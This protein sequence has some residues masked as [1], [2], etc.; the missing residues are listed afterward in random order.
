MT[1][2]Q[3]YLDSITTENM[4][5]CSLNVK[6]WVVIFQLTVI[7]LYNYFISVALNWMKW[8]LIFNLLSCFSLLYAD[9][10]LSVFQVLHYIWTLI[11]LLSTSKILR[12]IKG[13]LTCNHRCRLMIKDNFMNVSTKLADRDTM[14]VLLHMSPAIAAGSVI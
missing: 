11:I 14:I 6:L 9:Q 13:R 2:R 12:I 8:K 10:I 3:L 5:N 4:R 7:Y 1:C